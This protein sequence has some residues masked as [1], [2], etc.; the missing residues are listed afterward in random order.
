LNYVIGGLRRLEKLDLTGCHELGSSLPYALERVHQGFT[1]LCLNFI[2]SINNYTLEALAPFL[3]PLSEIGLAG[4]LV[5]H[6]CS[7]CP[8]NLQVLNCGAIFQG[9]K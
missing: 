7:P 2:P 5:G 6:V 4:A 1:K 9:R 8:V 3:A